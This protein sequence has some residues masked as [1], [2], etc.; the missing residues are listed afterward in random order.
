MYIFLVHAMYL[1][2]RVFL[3]IKSLW[4]HNNTHT[5]M[6]QNISTTPTKFTTTVTVDDKPPQVRLTSC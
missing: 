1:D 2:V 5:D 3:V 4:F 6:Q